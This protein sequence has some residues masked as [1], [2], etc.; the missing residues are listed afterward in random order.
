MKRRRAKAMK[1]QSNGCLQIIYDFKFVQ[2]EFEQTEG[3]IFDVYIIFQ[4][5]L[6]NEQT[7]LSFHGQTAD[8]NLSADEKRIQALTDCPLRVISKMVGP[9][10]IRKVCR[11]CLRQN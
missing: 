2:L 11:V 10:E 1:P 4:M 5:T 9:K 8:G 7:L 3:M 6:K